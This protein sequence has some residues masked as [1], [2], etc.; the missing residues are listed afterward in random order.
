MKNTLKYYFVTFLF[1]ATDF[2]AF[3]Q[4]GPGDEGDGDGGLEGTGDPQPAPINSKLVLLAI[5]G[6]LFVVYTYRKNR[7]IA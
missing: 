4:G 3:A 1:L 7:R 2:V 5:M 6:I